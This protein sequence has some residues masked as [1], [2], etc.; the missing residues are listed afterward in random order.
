M[1][2]KVL[3]LLVVVLALLEQ[4]LLDAADMRVARVRRRLDVALGDAGG[5]GA[6]IVDN[7]FIIRRLLTRLHLLLQSLSIGLN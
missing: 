3:V 1:R 2:R 7:V 6:A 5:R 4:Q